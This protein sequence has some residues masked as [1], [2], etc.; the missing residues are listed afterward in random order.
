MSFNNAGIEN[1]QIIHQAQDHQDIRVVIP[2]GFNNHP[3]DHGYDDECDS[4][5]INDYNIMMQGDDHIED[6]I[7][8][9]QPQLG[10][11]GNQSTMN[12]NNINQ[13]MSSGQQPAFAI[14]QTINTRYHT[15]NSNKMTP[16]TFNSVGRKQL[17]GKNNQ[18]TAINSEQLGEKMNKLKQQQ[19]EFKQNVDEDSVGNYADASSSEQNGE[20]IGVQQIE[21]DL[22]HDQSN[23]F[24]LNSNNT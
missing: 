18:K 1:N 14:G 3:P 15:K 12:E 20:H 5:L 24:I 22:V 23:K 19:S 10:Q 2:A 21:V 4:P 8:N 17:S 11:F 6:I 16:Q 13:Q 7:P 9:I